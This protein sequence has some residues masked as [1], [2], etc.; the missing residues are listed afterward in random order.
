M[1]K[2]LEWIFGGPMCNHIWVHH[3]TYN[4]LNTVTTCAKCNSSMEER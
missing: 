4:P 3:T 2:F 1:L